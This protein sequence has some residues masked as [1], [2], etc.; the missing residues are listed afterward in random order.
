MDNKTVNDLVQ[1]FMKGDSQLAAVFGL[2]LRRLC[3][4]GA[5]SLSQTIEDIQSVRELRPPG[6][7][8]TDYLLDILLYLLRETVDKP[9]SSTDTPVPEWLREVIEGGLSKK[10]D[11]PVG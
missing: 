7:A 8:E 10:Q 1:A 5:L 9:P 4:R 6:L 11:E 2:I 3:Q